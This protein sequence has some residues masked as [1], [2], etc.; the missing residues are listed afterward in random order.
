MKLE[1]FYYS[2]TFKKTNNIS[3]ETEVI[4]KEEIKKRKKVDGDNK[5]ISE[6]LL[7]ANAQ[8][9]TLEVKLR[10]LEAIRD[11]QQNIINEM[12]TKMDEYESSSK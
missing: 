1:N 10:E 7:V 4:L 8:I 11:L 2:N 5:I 12:K 6:K 3:L 9:E